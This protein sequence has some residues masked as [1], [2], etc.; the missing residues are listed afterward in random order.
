ML[1]KMVGVNVGTQPSD[2]AVTAEVNSLIDR[3]IAGGNTTSIMKG[4]CASVLGSAAMP[5]Q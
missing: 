3:L 5:V 2:V 1:E 4:T